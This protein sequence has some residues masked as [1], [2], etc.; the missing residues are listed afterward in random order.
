MSGI[1][2][3][4][5]QFSNGQNDLVHLNNAG[6]SLISK[7]AKTLIN[8][9]TERFFT[10]AMHCND[11]YLAAVETARSQLAKLVSCKNTEVAFFQ[12]TAGAVSQMAFGMELRPGDEVIMWDQ[13]YSSNLYPW[14]AAAERAGAKLVLVA[15]GESLETPVERLLKAVT[16]KT[17]V[18]AISWVQFQTGAVTDLKILGQFSRK[19]NI[20]TVIDVIQGLGM[21]PLNFAEL[22]LDAI[23][24]GSHKWLSSPV[25]VGYLVLREDRQAQVRP[26]MIG[27]G[28]YGTC[29]DPS[30]LVC[31]AKSS[32]HKFEAGSRQVLEIVGLGASCDLIY[33]TGVTALQAETE[34]LSKKL[35]E[36][37]K[38][39]GF[40]IHSPHGEKQIG[41]IVNFSGK[42]DWAEAQLKKN[43]ISYTVRGPGLRFSPHAFN[44]DED[45]VRAVNSLTD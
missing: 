28:T 15:S 21:M 35:R 26:L 37:L 4:K 2:E 17:K 6:I 42:H 11:A 30:S 34:R 1:G 19:H 33:A 16:A 32:A 44:T 20:W 10:E 31:V 45:I 5:K 36:G 27:S 13:E 8:T 43:Q 14:R 7:P 3:F 24:G 18:I 39:A 38:N 9:W 29:D 41:S 12:S 22:E 40:Q 23:C 25:G